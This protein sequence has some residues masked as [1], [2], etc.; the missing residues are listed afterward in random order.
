M[1]AQFLLAVSVAMADPAAATGAA[2]PLREVVFNASYTDL[3][4][5]N[6]TDYYGN[7]QYDS[8][9]SD[10]G[11][12]TVDIM[13]IASEEIGLRVT[14]TWDSTG[15]PH[16]YTGNVG[17]DCSVN[18][19]PNSIQMI[20]RQLL[21]YFCRGLGT[22]HA[23]ALGE[24]WVVNGPPRTGVVES[25][26]VQKVDGPRVT[27]HENRVSNTST[28]EVGD[29]SG[30]STVV[31]EPTKLVPISGAYDLRF[32]KS[33]FATIEEDTVTMKFDR[34]SDTLDPSP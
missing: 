13:E 14:E 23:Y 12:I 2:T 11:T 34:T 6:V 18:F 19:A 21:P 3:N 30:E 22:Q 15:T 8:H 31:Y 26:D 33:E 5:Q 17:T 32:A 9:K 1:L 4:T 24:K 16:V 27:V 7:K 28:V 20:T 29:F 25:F 10:R